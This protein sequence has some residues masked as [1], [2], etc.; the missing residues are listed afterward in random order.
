MSSDQ[1]PTP[2]TAAPVAESV[3]KVKKAGMKVPVLASSAEVL[4]KDPLKNYP[5]ASIEDS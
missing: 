4:R 1:T 5:E 3:M 2:S